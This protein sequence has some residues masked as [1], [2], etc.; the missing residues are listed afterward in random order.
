MKNGSKKRLS[1]PIGSFT[2]IYGPDGDEADSISVP[3]VDDTDLPGDIPR[4]EAKVCSSTFNVPLK[5]Q[6]H[7]FLEFTADIDHGS[8][9]FSGS[10]A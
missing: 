2:L 7:V 9:L 6:D 1:D 5:Y 3:S 10:I 8:I 4:G